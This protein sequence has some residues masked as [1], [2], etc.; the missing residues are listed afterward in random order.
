MPV[1]TTGAA[2]ASRVTRGILLGLALGLA[3]ARASAETINCTDVATLSS[4]PNSDHVIQTGGIYCLKSDLSSVRTI[5]S[6]IFVNAG[7]NNVVL[8]LNGHKLGGLSA[9][10]GTETV[11]IFA[12]QS[13]NVTIRNGTV[14]GFR[15][16]ISLENA[17]LASGGHL[18]EK[19]RVDQCTQVG[20]RVVGRGIIVRNNQVISTGGTTDGSNPQIFAIT[21]FGPGNRVINNDIITVSPQ[22]QPGTWITYG[23]FMNDSVG[24][25]TTV[26]VVRNR[27]T[28]AGFG[29]RF[30]NTSTGKYRGNR[31]SSVTTPYTGGLD[32]GDNH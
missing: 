3:A 8:D 1:T 24:S 2:M 13:Q 25:S 14:R 5:G 26:F 21:A 19:V 10:P 15:Y 27:I 23:I 7:V 6:A 9:G 20:I 16:G 12:P 17:N 22:G 18:I 11:G 32:A 30:E 31:T 29:I 4:G 28:D